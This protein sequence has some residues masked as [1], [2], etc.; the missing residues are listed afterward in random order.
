MSQQ[1]ITGMMIIVYLLWSN[2]TVRQTFT[3]PSFAKVNRSFQHWT[4]YSAQGTGTKRTQKSLSPPMVEEDLEDKAHMEI[5]TVSES[6][7]DNSH[8]RF[9]YTGEMGCSVQFENNLD[10][11]YTFVIRDETSPIID[12]GYTLNL[13]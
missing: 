12:D 4:A 7:L 11:S 8:H 2:P 1:F 9:M 6:S 10:N 13:P 5:Q 3:A